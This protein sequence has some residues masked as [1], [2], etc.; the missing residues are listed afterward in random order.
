MEHLLQAAAVGEVNRAGYYVELS[1]LERI[2]GRSQVFF[3]TH[4]G[5]LAQAAHQTVHFPVAFPHR[6]PEGDWSIAVRPRVGWYPLT[7]LAADA[8]ILGLGVWLLTLTVYEVTRSSRR[9]Q[10]AME[11][12][13]HRQQS[14]HARLM[15]EVEKRED[16][17]KSLDHARYHDVFTGLPNRRYFMDQLDRGLRHARTKRRYRLAV[18]LVG[19]DRFKLIKDTMGHTAGDELM[20]QVA[21]RFEKIATPVERVVSRWNAD[22][23]AVL[24]CDLHSID[25]ALSAA[26]M[27]QDGFAAPF[28]LRKQRIAV[29]ARFGVTC[30]DSGLHRAED[31]VREA[32]IALSAARPDRNIVPYD[33]KLC[34]QAMNVVHLEADLHVALQRRELRLLFQPIVHLYS[35]Q[36]VGSEALLR[37]NHPVEGLLTPDRFLTIAEEAGL[38]APITRWVIRRACKVAASWRQRLPPG[39]QFYVAVNLPAPLVED[40]RL[41]E[42]VARTLE[43][44][45]IAPELLRFEVTEGSLISNV[46]PARELLERLHQM[47]ISLALDDFGTG[48]SSLSYL[49]LFPF[50]CL[51]ID[52]SFVSRVGA[53]GSDS[54]LLRAIVQMA[55][56]LG[57][58]TVAE[59]IESQ[60]VAQL[61]HEIGCN[62]G[63]GFWSAPALEGEE[64]LQRLQAQEHDAVL[65]LPAQ[66]A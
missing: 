40:L 21:R 35:G 52:R 51:K 55:S 10:G 6:L 29:A 57:L 24:L 17:Q 25:T 23:F 62:F 30:V 1:Q 31:V 44:T 43:Q 38:M 37:W 7:E 11:A 15:S 66:S 47:G 19:I 61:L 12:S 56:S 5:V 16:L 46:G 39:V 54:A 42:Y 59:G 9:W 4:A 41:A 3:A 20:L 53:D 28:E 65:E 63:Q 32:D 34:E 45:G 49:Q 64:F 27:L 50:D 26:R 13:K 58:Q 22:Q 36:I 48:Y 18:I 2:S 33:G 14:A 8:A 60:T